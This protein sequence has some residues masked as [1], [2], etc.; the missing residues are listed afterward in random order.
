[1]I[2]IYNLGGLLVGLLGAGAFFMALVLSITLGLRSHLALGAFALAAV[3]IAGGFLWRNLTAQGRHKGTYPALFFIPLPFAGIAIALLAIPL[4]AVELWVGGKPPDP[5][6]ARFDAD[7]AALRKDEVGG[8]V[9]LSQAIKDEL[10]DLLVDE[11]E[12][13][14]FRVF[15]RVGP[16]AVLVLLQAPKLKKFTDNAR[17]EL[18]QDIMDIL[19][20]Q[21]RL[22]GKKVYIGIK[23]KVAFG[24][25]RVPPDKVEVGEVLSTSG[26]LD[27]YGP[28]EAAPTEAGGT[29]RSDTGRAGP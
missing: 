13:E 16:D 2:V 26:L 28:K 14:D 19:D 25:V 11:A 24:A 6:R 15:T 12:A 18:I 23:G 27:F 29:R 3:W 5:R 21:E 22:K 8:D 9:A 10:E 17:R 7:E 1:M 4:F 20:K